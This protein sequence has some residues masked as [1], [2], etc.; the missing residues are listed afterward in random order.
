ML[1]KGTKLYGILKMKCP[2]CHEGSFY[3][4]HPYNF[5]KMGEV[6]KQCSKCNLK[7][8]LEPSFYQGSYYV[9]YALGVVLFIIIGVLKLLFFPTIGPGA[10]LLTILISLMLLSPLF[11]ALSKIIWINFFVKYKKNFVNN[12]R[13]N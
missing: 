2:R 5:S 9:A 4:S 6:N 11:Y 13:K 10:L 7:F 1:G 3:N 12:S 8:S